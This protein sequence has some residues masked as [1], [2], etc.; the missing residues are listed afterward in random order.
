MLTRPLHVPSLAPKFP[1]V[2]ATACFVVS[3]ATACGGGIDTSQSDA[4]VAQARAYCTRVYDL[5][6]GV[7]CGARTIPENIDAVVRESAVRGCINAVLL[8][9]MADVS[10]AARCVAALGPC[11]GEVAV[12]EC[13][14][15]KGSL[16]DGA[17]CAASQQCA[18]GRCVAGDHDCGQCSSV[19][20]EGERC[21]ALA[22]D[23]GL[24]CDKGRSPAVCVAIV[25]AGEAAPCDTPTTRCAEGLFCAKSTHTCARLGAT[26]D[27]CSDGGRQ[28]VNNLVCLDGSCSAGKVE[29]ATC[30][31]RECAADLG[32]DPRTSKC[33]RRANASPGEP[34]GGVVDCW[35][36]SCEA[37][38]GRCPTLLDDGMACD[39]AS[40]ATTCTP[41]SRC[42]GGHCAPPFTNACR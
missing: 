33:A 36:G 24:V 35:V 22:C 14:P 1:A 38:L 41:Y 3:V 7:D 12:A 6:A 27:A 11:A 19:A 10:V 28:C 26:G 31:P 13:F 32:C 20:S 17:S 5:G 30:A 42:S 39:P 9:G 8:P 37:S 4:L 25:S 29:G 2:I 15:R 16:L 23:D 18:S 21:D 40:S 34:C